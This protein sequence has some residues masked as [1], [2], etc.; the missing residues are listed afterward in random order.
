MSSIRSR[1]VLPPRWPPL[2]TPTAPHC[3]PKSGRWSN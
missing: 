2:T 1:F 3:A